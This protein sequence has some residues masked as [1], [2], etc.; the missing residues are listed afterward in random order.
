ML[1]ERIEVW[2]L[3]LPL[4]EAFAAAHGTTSSRELAVVRVETDVG[5]GWGE[6]SA[7]PEPTYTAEYAAGAYQVLV[8]RLA[9]L[10]LGQ[11]LVAPEAFDLAA[12]GGQPMAKAAVEMA[13]IDVDCRMRSISLADHLGATHASVPAGAAVGLGPVE[14]VAARAAALAAEGFGRVKL[15]IQ[16]GHDLAVVAAVRAA[17]PSLEVQVDA[18]GSYGPDDMALLAELASAGVTAIEQPF[19]VDDVDSAA[20]LVGAAGVPVVADEAIATAADVD[21]LHS[22]GALS[23]VS[24][25]PPRVGGI[26]SA[27]QLLGRCVAAGLPAAAGGMVESALG[28]HALAAV[29]ALDGFTLTGDVSPAG[30]WLAADPWPDLTMT[31]NGISV[32]ASPG[33]APDPDPDILAS[34]TI[35]SAAIS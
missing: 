22:L 27:I 32:P 9:P 23:G 3:D 29:A 18:N 34:H 4:R 17:A 35:R 6:C 33:V 15:K 31:T 14:A 12:V 10:L 8:E 19:A 16:P 2:L 21:R 7:L 13:L 25:K 11:R 26:R 28:R 5:H 1:V 20:A 24:I 30:R